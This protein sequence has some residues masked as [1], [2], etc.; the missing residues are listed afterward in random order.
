MPNLAKPKKHKK[1]TQTF[2][3]SHTFSI[4]NRCHNCGKAQFQ[5][6]RDST[7]ATWPANLKFARRYHNASSVINWVE[8][9][10]SD[11]LY[12]AIPQLDSHGWGRTYSNGWKRFDPKMFRT[13]T[14]WDGRYPMGPEVIMIV[15][16]NC[17]VQRWAYM[18]DRKHFV[19]ENANR[20]ARI[21]LPTVAH[22]ISS[23]FW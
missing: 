5:F 20:K 15:C 21:K 3:A 1:P 14:T 10:N 17:G 16:G 13:F 18:S 4:R 8:W 11:Y 23:K 22:T 7:N 6:Y 12:Y 19:P 2:N 9:T